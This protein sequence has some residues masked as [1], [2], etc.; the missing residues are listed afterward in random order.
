MG[1]Y[2]QCDDTCTVDCGHCKGR[3]VA[4]LRAEVKRL[5]EHKDR[6][7]K[8]LDE[9]ERA[10]ENAARVTREEIAA[11]LRAAIDNDAVPLVHLQSSRFVRANTVAEWA[12][13][14]AEGHVLLRVDVE[15]GEPT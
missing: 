13:R 5:T 3:P 9:A 6:L 2:D 7:A 8:R 15:A 11:E 12:A 14:V 10:A 4:A 1:R